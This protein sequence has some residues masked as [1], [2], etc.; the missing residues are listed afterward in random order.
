M[1]D[2]TNMLNIGFQVI[3][4]NVAKESLAVFGIQISIS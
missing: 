1:K 3:A 2:E 4:Q